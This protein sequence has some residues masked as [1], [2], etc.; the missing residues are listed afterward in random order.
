M[1]TEGFSPA[2]KQIASPDTVIERLAGGYTFTEG[3]VWN[4]KERYLAWVDIIGDAIWKFTP[5]SGTS[6]IMK[7]SGKAGAIFRVWLMA[8][9]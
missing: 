1:P 3:P 7:P 9:R 8:G 6:I 4:G 2:F 5:G